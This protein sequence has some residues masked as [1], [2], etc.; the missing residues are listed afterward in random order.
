MDKIFAILFPITASVACCF[1]HSIANMYLIPI[2][3]ALSG[4]TEVLKAAGVTAVRVTNL[5]VLDF[6]NNLVPITLGN[7][8]GGTFIGSIYW[9][10]Y[11]RKKHTAEAVSC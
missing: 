7:T 5:N 4:Q 11:L 1:E 6:I 9:L 10:I 3:I 2:G 8:V